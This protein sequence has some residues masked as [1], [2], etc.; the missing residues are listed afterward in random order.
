MRD[1]RRGESKSDSRVVVP[2][3]SRQ[4]D[5]LPDEYTDPEPLDE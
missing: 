2:Y 4:L 3:V 5:S 1:R